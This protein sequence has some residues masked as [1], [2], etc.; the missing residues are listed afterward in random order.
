MLYAFISN[1][2]SHR[3]DDDFVPALALMENGPYA[4]KFDLET[5]TCKIGWF[6]EKSYS[7]RFH[8]ICGRETH[9]RYLSIIVFAFTTLLF[10]VAVIDSRAERV[11]MS[12]WKEKGSSLRSERA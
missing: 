12:S 5:W 1:H 11:L 7:D 2:R 3:L 10:A 9:S 8:A 6:Y 4:G